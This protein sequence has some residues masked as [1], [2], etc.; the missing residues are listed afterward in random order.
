MAGHADASPGA[1]QTGEELVVVAAA[2]AL[3]VVVVEAAAEG[4]VL[5]VAIVGTD[6]LLLV[7]GDETVGTR[8]LDDDETLE[9]VD[10]V[11]GG[12]EVIIVEGAA[13]IVTVASE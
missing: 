2:A 8:L 6:E 3:V 5:E 11:V 12:L 7:E 13:V 1:V 9:G 4:R 10:V